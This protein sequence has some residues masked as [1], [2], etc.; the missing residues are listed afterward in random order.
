[1]SRLYAK[2]DSDTIKGARCTGHRKMKI[3]VYFGSKEDSQKCVEM[4][5]EWKIDEPLPRVMVKE[6]A[7]KLTV[8]PY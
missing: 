5:V 7:G 2:I 4:E 6:W 1:M 3:L 8:K